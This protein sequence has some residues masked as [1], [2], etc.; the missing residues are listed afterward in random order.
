MCELDVPTFIYMI[1]LRW[2]AVVLLM[3]MLWMAL[4]SRVLWCGRKEMSS[5][6]SSWILPWLTHLSWMNNLSFAHWVCSTSMTH[7]RWSL[8]CDLFL[9]PKCTARS[10]GAIFF[11]WINAALVITTVAVMSC[12]K[13]VMGKQLDRKDWSATWEAKRKHPTKTPTNKPAPKNQQV[14]TNLWKGETGETGSRSHYLVTQNSKKTPA[15]T[16]SSAS[17]RKCHDYFNRL[18]TLRPANPAIHHGCLPSKSNEMRSHTYQ[19]GRAHKHH[20]NMFEV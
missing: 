12:A 7:L 20:Q 16:T 8:K 13:V 18:Y 6:M 14:K 11:F 1:N 4:S 15:L 10:G 5:R 3:A 2:G 9:N 19:S 17:C